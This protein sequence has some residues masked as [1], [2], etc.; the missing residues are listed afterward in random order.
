LGRLF[1]YIVP[2]Y[3]R[4]LARTGGDW[5]DPGL[6]AAAVG[7]AH[8][9]AGYIAD[10]FGRKPVLRPAGRRPAVGA[11]DVPGARPVLFSAA[12]VAYTFTGFVIA[13]IYAYATAA[14]ASRACSAR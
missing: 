4:Q 3:L 8:I 1:I 13:P 9:P 12:L 2:L 7:L 5:L 6:A 11:G 10:R 14:R